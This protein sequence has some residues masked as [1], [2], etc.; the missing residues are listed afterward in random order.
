MI[1]GIGEKSGETERYISSAGKNRSQ[2]HVTFPPPG[3]IGANC[4]LHLPRRE[5]LGPTARYISS[6]GKN[7]SQL[8][9]TFVP[10]GKIGAKGTLFTFQ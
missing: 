5:K 8:H 2:L 4:T 9:V 6:A 1:G 7:W 10:L 3:K